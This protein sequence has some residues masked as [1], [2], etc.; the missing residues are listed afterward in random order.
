L[1]SPDLDGALVAG[2]DEM[3]RFLFLAVAAMVA[4]PFAMGLLAQQGFDSNMLLLILVGIALL[5]WL[6]G[7]KS[8]IAAA[9]VL[10]LIWSFTYPMYQAASRAM[11]AGRAAPGQVAAAIIEAAK[12]AARRVLPGTGVGQNLGEAADDLRLGKNLCRDV[13]FVSEKFGEN[14]AITYCGNLG[15]GVFLD[16]RAYGDALE[17]GVTGAAYPFLEFDPA[18]LHSDTYLNCVSEAAFAMKAP[19][20]EC[21]AYTDRQRWRLCM[22][23]AIQITHDDPLVRSPLAPEIASCRAQHVQ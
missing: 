5:A 3:I 2:A 16:T 17:R 15:T 22:E 7:T 19:Y 18:R 4:L 13:A 9:V 6:K 8:L 21:A 12:T 23:L 11:A 20:Q 14:S 1:D 10:W